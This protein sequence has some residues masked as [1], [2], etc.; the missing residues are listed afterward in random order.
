MAVRTGATPG[1]GGRPSEL[2]PARGE[3][4][5][6]TL[7]GKHPFVARVLL[8]LFGLDAAGAQARPQSPPPAVVTGP[9][10]NAPPFLPIAPVTSAAVRAFPPPSTMAPAAEL[11]AQPAAGTCPDALRAGR[12]PTA[13]V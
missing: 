8:C 7:R 3:R 4:A 6:L 9:A 1:R 11:L 5:K 2:A 12:A 13:S 10:A